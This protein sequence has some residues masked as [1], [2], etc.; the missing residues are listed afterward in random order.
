MMNAVI[1]VLCASWDRLSPVSVISHSWPVVVRGSHANMNSRLP[2]F[3][4]AG[5]VPVDKA[6]AVVSSFSLPPHPIFSQYAL[7]K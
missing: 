5:S 4:F 2:K 1:S 6:V 7:Q 3:L